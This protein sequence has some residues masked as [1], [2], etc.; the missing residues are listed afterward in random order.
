MRGRLSRFGISRRLL[1]YWQDRRGDRDLP[2]R[3]DID[4]ADL[5]PILPYLLLVNV[6]HNPIDF[7]YRLMD[8]PEQRKPSAIWSLYE[9]TVRERRPTR[10]QVPYIRIEGKTIEM[11][12]LPLSSDGDT[13][14]ML[15]G[16]VAFDRDY[17]NS[18]EL[19]AI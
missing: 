18:D 8:L 17:L 6:A 15:I 4:P 5:V 10:T 11:Q 3:C 19:P 16:S 9:T 12:A 1:E 2:A 14:D 13:I 7:D